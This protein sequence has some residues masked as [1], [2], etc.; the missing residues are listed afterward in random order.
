MF[1]YLF[2]TPVLLFLFNA[3][4]T[5]RCIW[6]KLKCRKTFAGV[7][8]L[9]PQKGSHNKHS[10]LCMFRRNRHTCMKRSSSSPVSYETLVCLITHHLLHIT[11]YFRTSFAMDVFRQWEAFSVL[12]QGK[13]WERHNSF[14]L[15]WCWW[16][17]DSWESDRHLSNTKACLGA[18]NGICMFLPAT[19]NI[20]KNMI[21]VKVFSNNHHHHQKTKK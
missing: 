6:H 3:W 19:E 1:I 13:Q 20:S 4:K 15:N 2:T 14:T 5:F 10:S 9:V 17:L 18:S 12:C 11:S 8:L 7:L 16:C 21:T